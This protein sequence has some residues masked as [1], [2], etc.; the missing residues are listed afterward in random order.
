MDVDGKLL[1]DATGVWPLLRS[2]RRHVL[3][4]ICCAPI[5]PAPHPLIGNSPCH[6]PPCIYTCSSQKSSTIYCW[7]TE[8]VLRLDLFGFFCQGGSGIDTVLRLM[9]SP[10]GFALLFAGHGMNMANL[11]LTLMD[12]CVLGAMP[13]HPCAIAVFGS[14]YPACT[15]P[16][17]GL[18]SCSRKAT[19]KGCA[20]MLDCLH[21]SL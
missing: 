14:H 15:E 1:L 6:L 19:T 5:C 20:C 8:K 7:M 2:L 11:S 10:Q 16:S 12:R 3:P 17:G 21:V 9:R 18:M 13:A 4:S